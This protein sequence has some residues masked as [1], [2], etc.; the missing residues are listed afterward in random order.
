MANLIKVR[1]KKNYKDGA[2]G[3]GKQVIYFGREYT[4]NLDDPQVKQAYEHFKAEGAFAESKKASKPN[5]EKD[6]GKDKGEKDQEPPKTEDPE[7]VAPEPEKE[8]EPEPAKEEDVP[9]PPK[10]E[11]TE[12]AA[13]EPEKEAEPAKEEKSP[14]P[15]KVEPED[16][17]G[18]ITPPLQEKSKGAEKRDSQPTLSGNPAKQHGDKKSR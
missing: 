11:P 8:A 12:P 1:L 5:A 17:I 18:G 3:I 10:E 14:E 7:P 4:L 6:T 2:P 16:Q 13:Q 15:P 9:E